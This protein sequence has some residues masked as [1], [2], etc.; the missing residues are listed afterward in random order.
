M[1]NKNLFGFSSLSDYALKKYGQRP[2]KNPTMPKY[3]RPKAIPK[4]KNDFGFYPSPFKVVQELIKLGHIEEYHTVL[5]PSAGHGAILDEIKKITSSFV[6]GEIQEENKK[7]L[8]SKGYT[9]SFND[10]LKYNEKRFD[11]II[12]N[13]PF[14]QQ[15]DLNHVLHAY[16]LLNKGGRLVSVMSNGVTFRDNNKTKQFRNLLENNGLIFDLPENSFLET[17]TKVKTVIIVLSKEAV[18]P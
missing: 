13:P 5:E 11:R 15:A 16:T 18:Q 9:V 4:N 8:E 1:S 17:G 3:E 6:C 10:F 12:M 2:T 14:F 7:I